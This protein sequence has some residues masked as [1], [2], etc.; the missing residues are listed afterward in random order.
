MVATSP[1][2]P[3]TSFAEASTMIWR[4]QSSNR[5]RSISAGGR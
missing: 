1:V 2:I 5:A 3:P 4:A